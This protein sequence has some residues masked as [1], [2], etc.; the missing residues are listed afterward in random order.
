MVEG[1]TKLK[2]MLSL[3]FT[4]TFKHVSI[5]Y[6]SYRTCNQCG[7]PTWMSP[8]LLF[9]VDISVW[10]SFRLSLLQ[11][12]RC[13]I[14]LLN[15]HGYRSILTCNECVIFLS[16]SLQFLDDFCPVFPLVHSVTWYPHIIPLVALSGWRLSVFILQYFAIVFWWIPCLPTMWLL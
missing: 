7:F 4:F 3:F 5:D 16:T 15:I 11:V 2:L 6:A 10:P 13:V 1:R 8:M 9:L 14:G 12:F